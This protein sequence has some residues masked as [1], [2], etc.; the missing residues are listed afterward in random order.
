MGRINRITCSA[1]LREW[2][3]RIGCGLMHACLEDVVSE[4]PEETGREI[5]EQIGTEEF[6]VFD[7]AYHCSV[8]RECN[9]IVSVPI[10]KFPDRGTEY[11]GRCPG[12]GGVTQLI[13]DLGGML[14]PVCGERA[15]SEEEAGSWD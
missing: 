13:T 9:S 4:F 1:C 11:M 8:C 3:C 5:T 10:L 6:P 2:Q 12:C 14:C 15:L 7:F